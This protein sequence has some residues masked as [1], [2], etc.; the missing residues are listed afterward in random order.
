MKTKLFCL[1]VL[2]PLAAAP[3]SASTIT[4][5]TGTIYA[6][7]QLDAIDNTGRFGL[8]YGASLVGASYLATWSLPDLAE[9]PTCAQTW[10]M[11]HVMPDNAWLEVFGGP[12]LP[13]FGHFSAV[14]DPYNLSYE[15]VYTFDEFT[16]ISLTPSGGWFSYRGPQYAPWTASGNL[17]VD[18]WTVRS[19]E[20]AV[21]PIPAVGLPG[22]GLILA[23][24]GLLGWW[25]RR[26]KIA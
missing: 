4:F 12:R 1:A 20:V 25:R 26:Q 21:V 11:W 9:C 19:S 24:G 3:A 7:P 22:L 13:S 16:A 17:T 14:T 5:V 10:A 15:E 2:L 18:S 23:G 8:G 6:G